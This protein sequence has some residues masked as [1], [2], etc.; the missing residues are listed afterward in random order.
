[1]SRPNNAFAKTKTKFVIGYILFAAILISA[2]IYTTI[3]VKNLITETDTNDEQS[4]KRACINS[5]LTHLFNA[6]SHIG[7]MIIDTNDFHSYKEDIARASLDLERL[8]NYCS[9]THISQIDSIQD[10]MIEKEQTLVELMRLTN[11]DELELIYN[12]NLLGII[13]DNKGVKE[14]EKIVSTKTIKQDTIIE[15][16]KRKRMNFFRRFFLLF[17]REEADTTLLTYSSEEI[18]RDSLIRHYNPADSL[19]SFLNEIKQTLLEE[20]KEIDKELTK[21]VI[22]LRKK[23]NSITLSIK[24]ILKNIETEGEK[25]YEEILKLRE[26][27]FKKISKQLLTAIIIAVILII[28]FTYIISNDIT[29]SKKYRLE[30]EKSNNYMQKLLNDKEKLMLSISHDMKA[31]LGSTIGYIELMNSTTLNERQRYYL[32]NMQK[33]SEEI[34]QLI[35]NILEN[36]QLSKGVFELNLIPFSI[37]ELFD[38]IHI[39]FLPIAEKKGVKLH[40]KCLFNMDSKFIGDPLRIKQIVNN[41]LSNA[42]KFTDTGEISLL[43]E[44]TNAPQNNQNVKIVVKDSG[45][46]IP[47]SSQA[48][49]FEEFS[50]IKNKGKENIEGVGLGLSIVKKLVDLQKGRIELKS[51]SGEGSEFTIYLPLEKQKSDLNIKTTRTEPIR[52]LVVDDDETQ[53]ILISE[54]LKK[55]ETDVTTS[56]SADSA[57]KQ[58]E[59]NTFDIVFTD[60]Q[61]PDINGF[62]FVKQIRNSTIKKVYEI[63]IIALSARADISDEEMKQRGFTSFLTKPYSAQKLIQT[64]N[65]YLSISQSLSSH[66]TTNEGNNNYQNLLSFACGDKEAEI[67]ILTS[68]VKES[69]KGIDELLEKCNNKEFDR[70]KEIAHKLRPL[71]LSI[72]ETIIASNLGKLEVSDN[73]EEAECIDI[74]DTI[75]EAL[76]ALEKAEQYLNQ[77]REK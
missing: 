32:Q 71:F 52:A 51:K 34:L 20:K 14:Y 36:E 60:I 5:T 57:L 13:D 64:L 54:I 69:K 68:F 10:L 46:G 59:S 12:K 43:V 25:E 75:E 24:Q 22:E 45:L 40:Y 67:E 1:M 29:K 11:Q 62:D 56:T 49:I 16:R 72:E 76:A 31:P 61:M 42:F 41:L 55:A 37:K 47:K 74:K 7:P 66:T 38:D 28:I 33:S 21:N 63:P 58:L 53:L 6:E 15:P 4:E 65:T 48:L 35:S 70:C 73:W 3:D 27:R 8:K 9:A 44:N 19:Y 2:T 18:I 30:L 77:M 50:R 17:S 23:N 39:S 26:E